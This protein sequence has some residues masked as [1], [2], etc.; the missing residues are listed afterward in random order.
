MDAALIRTTAVH[1]IRVNGDRGAF[2]APERADEERV[3]VGAMGDKA[4]VSCRPVHMD[5]KTDKGRAP[6]VALFNGVQVA[7]GDLAKIRRGDAARSRRTFRAVRTFR[8]AREFPCF[9]FRQN[10]FA[11]QTRGERVHH[12]V[13]A[14]PAPQAVGQTARGEHKIRAEKNERGVFAIRL[15]NGRVVA[16]GQPIQLVAGVA[17]GGQC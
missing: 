1:I 12:I 9:Q 11:D 8:A 16:F 2:A 14:L 5:G 15:P 6:E 4:L 7:E 3:Q 17:R 10:G 13:A